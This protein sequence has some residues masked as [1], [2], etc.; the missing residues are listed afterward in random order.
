MRLFRKNKNQVKF[1][2]NQDFLHEGV[3]FL[4]GQVYKADIE[5]VRYFERNGWIEGSIAAPP[6]V[7]NLDIDNSVLG[8]KDSK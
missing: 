2:P 1:A 5:Q 7:V 8:T 6:P 3:R 4:K